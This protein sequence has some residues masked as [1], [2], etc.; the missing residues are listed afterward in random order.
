[1]YASLVDGTGL[2]LSIARRLVEIMSGGIQAHSE[3]GVGTEIFFTIPQKVIDKTPATPISVE[4]D[5]FHF[6]APRARVLI[7]DDNEMNLTIAKAHL[8]PIK[9]QVD[10][11]VNGREALEKI[12]E[13]RYDLVYMDHMMP[14]MDGIEAVHKIREQEGD[15][16]KN[17]PVVALSA[18]VLEK[19]KKLFKDEGMDDFLEK[20]VKPMELISMTR[21]WIPKEKIEKTKEAT[22]D[23]KK[24]T[25]LPVIE[26]I[27][28]EEGVKYSG[29]KNRWLEMLAD[30]YHIIDFKYKKIED[31][32]ENGD[33]KSYTIEVHALKNTARLIGAMELSEE[34]YELERLGDEEKV[35]EIHLK[36]KNVL[37]HFLSYKKVLEPFAMTGL[38][39]TKN[40][41]S[42]EEIIEVLTQIKDAMDGFDLDGA[43]AG[44]EVLNTYT[45]PEEYKERMK[46]LRALVADVAMEDVIKETTALIEEL[47]K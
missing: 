4:G 43:D 16:Y 31:D 17:L 13:N 44:M 2:E 40:V 28:S 11:A 22:F 21:R 25:D 41:V 7:V 8:E 10:L 34:F 19:S 12:K 26:G 39:A 5:E 18:N 23:I 36:T 27:D 33:I 14:E 6:V 1:L 45:V 3:K 32:L 9:V 35:E 47:T 42:N 30:F 20:P 37:E 46:K 38:E 15:Y 29:S 24:E